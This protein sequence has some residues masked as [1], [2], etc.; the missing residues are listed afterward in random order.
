MN[1][2]NASTPQSLFIRE[3]RVI[4]SK[5]LPRGEIEKAVYTYL[6][7][8]RSEQDVEQARAA[9]E[10]SYHDLGFQTVSVSVPPQRPTNGI[11]V[12]QVTEATVGRLRV[13][14][15]RFYSVE[16]IKKMAPS[17]EEGT[18]PNFNDVQRD[19]IGLNQIADRQVTPSLKPGAIPGTVDVELTVKDKLPL[20]GSI[21]LNNRYS[22]N[23]TPLRLDLA[24]RYDNL[25]Q[26]GHTIG[27]GF[28]IAP[29]RPDDALV[30]SGYYIAR[31]PAIDWLGLMLQATRQNSNVA[32]LGGTNSLG[33]GEIYGARFLVNLPARKGFFH[34]LS[35]GMDYKHF[36]QD[37]TVGN[38]I[39]SSPVSYWPFSINYNATS[40]GKNYETQLSAGVTFS[41]RGTSA[42]EQFEFDNR[43]YNA[44]SNFFYFRGSL[45]HTQ[46]LPGD[47]QLFAGVQ[48]QASANP[49][50]DTEQFSLGGLS[51]VR[52]Y[53][54]SVVVGD[55][56]LCGSLEL[57]SPSLLRWLGEGHECRVFVFL[58]GGV[59]TLN[60]PL[61]EQTS[62][63][64]LWS[65][66]IGGTIKIS[67]HV[68][69]EFI[70]GIPKV[71]QAPSE[72]NQPLFTFRLWAE[73]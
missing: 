27:L 9:L 61:P 40:I 18:V 35:V 41:F 65:Y 60:D 64:N 24:L 10:K 50:L 16:Q 53:L 45:E 19:I 63:F 67:D 8:G 1:Q 46:K 11:V 17:L 43:R 44:D 22:A 72:A 71:T 38:S 62:Q 7:P 70:I 52:G 39:I 33:N 69:G 31:L 30:Y 49:L 6:G 51:T 14:G 47:F 20:H 59:A 28:Q 29:Q 56:A 32:T 2:I 12:L 57:R 23:T 37:L 21:E 5:T 48:G 54:E 4:G 55:N 42:Q 13:K 58:D 26:L 15:S 3:Y 36:I 25:W 34:S 66:G 73:L 68:N